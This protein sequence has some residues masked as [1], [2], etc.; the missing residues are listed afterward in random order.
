MSTWDS[1]SAVGLG[2]PRFSILGSARPDVVHQR[3]GEF[4]ELQL[5]FRVRVVEVPVS[6]D[7][8]REELAQER[9][10]EAKVEAVRHESL[11]H[12]ENMLAVPIEA[13]NR[14]LRD[15]EV[16]MNARRLACDLVILAVPIRAGTLTCINFSV[17]LCT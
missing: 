9:G 6:Q 8:L 11:L 10:E 4:I 14:R 1:P 16:V 2:D 15:S 5:E 17:L 12:C 3:E 7:S 13:V